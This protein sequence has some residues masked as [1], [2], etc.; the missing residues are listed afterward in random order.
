MF[1][2]LL[3]ATNVVDSDHFENYFSCFKMDKSIMEEP[4]EKYSSLLCPVRVT[5]YYFSVTKYVYTSLT[6]NM[7]PLDLSYCAIYSHTGIEKF[8]TQQ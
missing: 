1:T 6:R 4:P 3:I 2:S 7:L 5:I 8:I